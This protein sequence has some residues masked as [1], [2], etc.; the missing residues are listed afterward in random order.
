MAAPRKGWI[1]K[2]KALITENPDDTENLPVGTLG[3]AR[4]N[5]N[6][7]AVDEAVNGR[8]PRDGQS[9]DRANGY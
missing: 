9:S 8:R 5:A 7:A 4:Y 2:I 1:D 6:E 3:R